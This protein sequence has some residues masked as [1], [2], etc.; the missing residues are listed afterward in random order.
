[1]AYD[2]GLAARIRELLIGER[3]LVE[4][5]MFGGL[6]M[7]LHGNMAVGVHGDGLMVRADPAQQQALLAEPGARV[8]DMTGRPMKGWLVVDAAAVAEDADL[9]RWLQRGISYART[10]PAK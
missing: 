2:E 5:K 9:R 8:F 1:M 6:A 3:G 4:K 10:L 7:M